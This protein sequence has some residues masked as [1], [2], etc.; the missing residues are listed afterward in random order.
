MLQ[1]TLWKKLNL[2]PRCDNRFQH[3][4]TACSFAFNFEI[5]VR[6]QKC[7]YTIFVFSCVKMHHRVLLTKKFH[8]DH[9]DNIMLYNLYDFDQGHRHILSVMPRFWVAV[10]LA[11]TWN[12]QRFEFSV[13]IF[14]SA[15][16]CNVLQFQL[17]KRNAKQ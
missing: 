10:T 9:R 2:K 4:I 3:V 16:S 6:S 11:I 8:F 17:W 5:I 1:V 7:C 13:G 12:L 15:E 14:L